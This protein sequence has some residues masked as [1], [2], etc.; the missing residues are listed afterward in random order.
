M[1]LWRKHMADKIKPFETAHMVKE[2]GFDYIY[3]LELG[4]AETLAAMIKVTKNILTVQKQYNGALKYNERLYWNDAMSDVK[5]EWD[6]GKK[7]VGNKKNKVVL[8]TGKYSGPRGQSQLFGGKG[9]PSTVILVQP[10]MATNQQTIMIQ[11]YQNG[12]T[13]GDK[14]TQL[15]NAYRDELW[16]AWV[17]LLG[18]EGLEIG[19]DVPKTTQYAERVS[20]S[21][22]DVQRA[23]VSTLLR[24]QATGDHKASSTRSVLALRELKKA[25]PGF[26]AGLTFS[27]L[28]IIADVEKA[29]GIDYMEKAKRNKGG[30]FLEHGITWDS[31]IEVRIGTGQGGKHPSGKETTDRAPMYDAAKEAVTKRIQKQFDT[32]GL[33]EHW[34]SVEQ[35]PYSKR[36]QIINAY[37]HDVVNYYKKMAKAKIKAVGGVPFKAKSVKGTIHKGGRTSPI[38]KK[39]KKVSIAGVPLKS[40]G[41]ES[42]QGEQAATALIAELGRAKTYINKRLPAEVRRNMGRPAL[43]NRTGMFSGSAKL[44]SL[45][46]AANSIVAKYTYMLTGGGVS[47]N[48]EGV[49]QTFENSGRWPLGYNPKPLIAKSIRNLAKGRIRQKLT[50]RR[51]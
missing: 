41:K 22:G 27:E 7:V 34:D 24:R 44:L 32:V 1:K 14:A 47:K 21:K 33:P 8:E 37:T 42:G 20:K 39:R 18:K 38:R 50:L 25:P 31:Y 48:R 3:E 15:L 19:T 2:L 17:D 10:G 28:D 36:E 46:P 4:G 26:D 43:I 9:K 16:D 49:Y 29:L 40:R 30:D 51:S 12:K 6:S 23:R 45:R 13:I 35:S 5:K 11:I